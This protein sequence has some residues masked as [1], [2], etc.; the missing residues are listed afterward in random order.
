MKHDRIVV[1]FRNDLRL[2]DNET[3]TRALQRGK[4]I[5][6][7]YC[8]DSRHFESTSLGFAK[9]GAFRVQFLLESVADLRQSFQKIGGDLVILHGAPEQMVPQFAKKLGATAIYF[10][11]EVTAEERAVD[12]AL[13]EIA[14]AQGIACES[15]WQSSLYHKDDLPFPIHLR[16]LLN[17]E[18]RS[19]RDAK[20]ALLFLHR[21]KFHTLGKPQFLMQESCF[22]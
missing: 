13:E 21:N 19:K 6:P 15:F 17:S 7:V 14:F 12:K 9:T 22:P 5:I 4:E 20:S 11:K 18:K 3:L 10:S 2:E 1:W 16:C 8:F